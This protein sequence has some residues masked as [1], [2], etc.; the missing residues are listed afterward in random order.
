M[1]RFGTDRPARMLP[2]IQS[3]MLGEPRRAPGPF[4]NDNEEPPPIFRTWRRLYCAI[5]AYL[6]LLITL[7]Y[8]FSVSFTPR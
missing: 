6:A 1:R 8:L 5:V 7:F 4:S 3:V 2:I